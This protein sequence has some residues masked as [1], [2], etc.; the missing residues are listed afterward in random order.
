MVGREDY[1][2]L[3]GFSGWT[4]EGIDRLSTDRGVIE[5]EARRLGRRGKWERIPVLWESD[6]CVKQDQAEQLEASQVGIYAELR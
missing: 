2:G 1:W 4:R 5:W 6:V 3:G